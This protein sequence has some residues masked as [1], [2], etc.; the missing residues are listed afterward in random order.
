MMISIP[1]APCECDVLPFVIGGFH[2]SIHCVVSH[3]ECAALLTSTLN[4]SKKQ[5]WLCANQIRHPGF[6]GPEFCLMLKTTQRA[7]R[8][9][10]DERRDVGGVGC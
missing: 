9:I 1:S 4:R 3:L 5:R 7:G 8:S 2:S 10:Q 6:Q